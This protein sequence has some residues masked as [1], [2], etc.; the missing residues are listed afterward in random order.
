METNLA[1][2]EVVQEP[3]LPELDTKT[4]QRFRFAGEN[5]FMNEVKSWLIHRAQEA[6]QVTLQ[7][8]SHGQESPLPDVDKA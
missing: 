3:P 6:A 5:P 4:Q 8:G 7:E 2:S 1:K